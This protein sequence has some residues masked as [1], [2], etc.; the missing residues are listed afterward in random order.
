MKQIVSISLGNSKDDYEF[1]AEFMGQEFNIKRVGTDGD[2]DMAADLMEQWDSEADAISLGGLN[3]NY[4]IG[5]SRS[6]EKQAIKVETLKSRIASPA[7][8]GEKLRRVSFEWAIRHLQFKF[9][10]NYFNH[11]KVLFLSGRIVHPYQL[12]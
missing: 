3:F 1:V 2:V 11:T 5:S 7:T 10:N 12:V 9:G 6:I 4:A 8:T